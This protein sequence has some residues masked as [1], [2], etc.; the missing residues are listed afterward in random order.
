MSEI[1]VTALIYP[2]PEKFDEV[3]RSLDTGDKPPLS[4]SSLTM[5]GRCL[6]HRSHQKGARKRTRHSALL[7][8]PSAR[9]EG[10]RNCRKVSSFPLISCLGISD[11]ASQGWDKAR[12][13][14][15]ETPDIRT[16]RPCRPTSSQPIFATLPPRWPS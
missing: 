11:S 4:W 15:T 2:Q 14:L 8:I 7:R 5:S 12:A 3:R 13:K 10:D 1:N 16:R 6:N 9:Q